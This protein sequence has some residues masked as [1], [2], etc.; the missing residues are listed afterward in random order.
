M[1]VGKKYW[2]GIKDFYIHEIIT[3]CY[4]CILKHNVVFLFA[5]YLEIVII[6]A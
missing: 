3:V 6:L 4:D 2:N 5:D 1:L